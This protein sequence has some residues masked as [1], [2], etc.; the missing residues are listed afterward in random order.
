MKMGSFISSSLK[1]LTSAISGKSGVFGYIFAPAYLLYWLFDRIYNFLF[2]TV[3][4]FFRSVLSCAWVSTLV[5]FNCF[6]SW[7]LP[8]PFIK[9]WGRIEKGWNSC[10][11][12]KGGGGSKKGRRA[13]DNICAN[14]VEVTNLLIFDI[15]NLARAVLYSLPVLF[16]VAS[17]FIVWWVIGEP[18]IAASAGV[19]VANDTID[20]VVKGFAAFVNIFN[21]VINTFIIVYNVLNP[22]FMLTFGLAVKT[23][24]QATASLLVVFDDPSKPN[25]IVTRQVRELQSDPSYNPVLREA[26]QTWEIVE[27]T[28]RTT[29]T[30][31]VVITWGIGWLGYIIVTSL[32]PII[33]LLAA[34]IT[35]A[36][37]KS[38]RGLADS[39]VLFT[40]CC[41]QD[42]QASWCCFRN[43]LQRAFD[44]IGFT[45][46]FKIDIR[47]KAVD[48]PPA[49][50]CKC[51]IMSGGPFVL[52][53]SCKNPVYT[54]IQS[55]AVYT[56]SLVLYPTIGN[57][58]VTQQLSKGVNKNK[59]C[60]NW[61]RAPLSNPNARFLLPADCEETED[62]CFESDGESWLF[63][64]CGSVLKG[65]CHTGRQL[66]GEMWHQHLLKFKHAHPLTP[67][68]LNIAPPA[69]PIP[70][71]LKRDQFFD[72]VD[73]A[74]Q[75]PA[76]Q[77]VRLEC[78][79][80]F[81]IMKEDYKHFVWRTACITLKMID[82]KPIEAFVTQQLPGVH[83][84]LQSNLTVEHVLDHM[85]DQLN[86][87]H[88][89]QRFRTD[90]VKTRVLM[91]ESIRKHE[92]WLADAVAEY[93]KR[94]LIEVENQADP[95]G[96]EGYLCPDGE[97]KLEADDS[98]AD[99]P[100]PTVWSPGTL[101]RYLFYVVSVAEQGIDLRF[102]INGSIR[103]FQGYETNPETDPTNIKNILDQ[104]GFLFDPNASSDQN[105]V[106]CFPLFGRI[107][108]LPTFVWDWK[109]WVESQCQVEITSSGVKRNVC[110]C[111]Q[112]NQ[113]TNLFNYNQQWGT[114][115]KQFIQLRLLNS[116]RGFQYLL[117]RIPGTAVL[118]TVWQITLSL[119][120]LI[121]PVPPD[122][123]YMFNANYANYGQ[124][125][126]TNW[127]CLLL[128]VGSML[129]TVIWVIVPA[130]AF[131]FC[132]FDALYRLFKDVWV[133]LCVPTMKRCYR[134]S[135]RCVKNGPFLKG[136][137]ASNYTLPEAYVKTSQEDNERRLEE[138]VKW[139]DYQLRKLI[140]RSKDIIVG[141]TT[142]LQPPSEQGEEAGRR[143]L[144]R[145]HAQPE[146]V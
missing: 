122:V 133:Y 125:D 61:L 139:Q 112:Y 96:N 146:S 85:G 57:G 19:D 48:L 141:Q 12:F 100:M 143:R 16:I 101:F 95:S 56:E 13:T 35:G 82:S 54:C 103:C 92:R 53:G 15:I 3:L 5:L 74:E 30:P 31:A 124:T 36:I 140:N 60:R 64:N 8:T 44:G 14:S 32:I 97:T 110:V 102:L 49:T 20:V 58:P 113:T 145:R 94:R 4:D 73:Q 135:R 69:P 83:R 86:T 127:F 121:Y 76:G 144:G 70:D 51:D 38:G 11:P 24:L 66:E 117:T 10:W 37:I 111:S 27:G 79:E 68:P 126:N 89:K 50:F 104:L 77:H 136:T 119:F 7:R 88:G 71:T 80:K 123:L 137:P 55:G 116:W 99:C 84:F 138:S 109:K 75:R 63:S 128:N 9:A 29:L 105:L 34:A 25:G 115:S 131:Y 40:G 17:L 130:L 93:K 26:E 72:M 107:D 108:Y 52:S 65:R 90:H 2:K 18:L 59:V 46:L 120:H 23:L 39:P 132:Y 33:E 67:L 134:R 42:A 45:Q 129:W 98:L 21:N 142:P 118:D 43:F 106:Y 1:S 47:C 81:D 22:F 114:V 78:P 91:E 87:L 62:Y 28:F 6:K 41:V